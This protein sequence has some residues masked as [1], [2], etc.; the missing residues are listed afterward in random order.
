MIR[1]VLAH[2]SNL[3]CDLLREALNNEEDV[4]LVGSATTT[5]E[6]EFLLPHTSIVLL[7]KELEGGET[8]DTLEEIR[9]EYPDIKILVLEVAE[10]PEMIL[11]YIEAGADGYI[12]QNES[13]DMMIDK[14]QAAS[15]EKALVSPSVTAALMER[16]TH[17]ANLE[18]PLAYMEARDGMIEKLTSR[19]EEVLG[20]VSQGLTNKEIAGKLFIECGTVKNHVHNILKKL[21]ANSRYEASSIYQMENPPTATDSQSRSVTA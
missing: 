8:L 20:L 21:D 3:V 12:L 2:P 11:K 17:L 14:L 18:T 4:H 13:V 7:S 16:L 15:E 5:E 10:Q 9:E 6:L 1:V 19:E